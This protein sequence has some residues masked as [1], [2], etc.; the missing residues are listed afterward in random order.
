MEK[1]ISQTVIFRF[2]KKDEPR[3][4][5]QV[6]SKDETG[7]HFVEIKNEAGQICPKCGELISEKVRIGY[8]SIDE[9][10]ECLQQIKKVIQPDIDEIK[11]RLESE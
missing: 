10:I 8:I 9:L 4:V 1:T 7:W 6:S 11:T 2:T 3:V 5:Y